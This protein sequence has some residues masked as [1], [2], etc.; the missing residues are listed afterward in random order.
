MQSD[1]TEDQLIE[2]TRRRLVGW[3]AAEVHLQ[4]IEKGGSDRCYYRVSAGGRFRGPATV[5]L[6]VYTDRRPDNLSFFAA[7]EVLALRKVRTPRVYFHDPGLRLGWMEDLGRLDLW[8]YRNAAPEERLPLYR[9]VLGQ[10]AQIHSLRLPDIPDQLRHRLQPPF[11]E[12]LYRWE[13]DYFFDHFA[14][15]FSALPREEIDRIR[16]LP[17]FGDLAAALAQMPRFMVHRDFQSQNVLVREGKTWLIDYQGLRPG[18]PE[19][20]LASLLYDPY[21]SLTPDER[22]D[23]LAH[24]LEIRPGDDQWDTN[25]DILAAC[26]SQRLMQALGAYGNLGLNQDKPAFLAYIPRAVE[27]LLFVLD[28]HGVLPSLRS[29]LQIRERNAAA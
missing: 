27:N 15:N 26:C 14:N 25:P 17:E 24:Y 12:S 19:Y 21:V 3:D 29:L 7:T 1:F 16:Q 9:D 6:M 20:D 13:Q 2:Q 22:D 23:L 5:I 11:D 28:R 4:K 10:A 18:R 8:E